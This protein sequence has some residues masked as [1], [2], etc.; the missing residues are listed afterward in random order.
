LP[1]FCA[2]IPPLRATGQEDVYFFDPVNTPAK[3]IAEAIHKTFLESGRLRLRVRVR[4]YAR[5]QRIVRDRV[6]PL[7]AKGK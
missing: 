2:D 7:L 1:V 5:W 6:L 4:K 3:T